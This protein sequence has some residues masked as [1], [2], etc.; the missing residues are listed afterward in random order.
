M[1]RCIP[2]QICVARGA[3]IWTL[4]AHYRRNRQWN[5]V[6]NDSGSQ[7]ACLRLEIT[8]LGGICLGLQT[9]LPWGPRA[10]GVGMWTQA[11]RPL[12]EGSC[13]ARGTG[14]VLASRPC[15]AASSPCPSGS[16][17]HIPRV[18]S[19]GVVMDTGQAG[20]QE[21]MWGPGK[22]RTSTQT[23]QALDERRLLVPLGLGP[24]EHTTFTPQPFPGTC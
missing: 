4:R 2:S 11:R 15:P 13:W 18:A 14:S 16:H 24:G 8:H 17:A 3:A 6:M 22:S 12:A 20:K 5:L 19:A 23:A 9:P 1:L 21:Q 7:P 10:E